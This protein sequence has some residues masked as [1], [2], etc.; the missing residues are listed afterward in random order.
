M[1]KELY[2]IIDLVIRANE[3]AS[4]V[5]LDS[6]VKDE[7]RA[8]MELCRWFPP[9]DCVAV[10]DYYY[11]EFQYWERGKT[12]S[13]LTLLFEFDYICLIY[14]FVSSVV[15]SRRIT[16]YPLLG[17]AKTSR[18]CILIVSTQSIFCLCR[19]CFCWSNQVVTKVGS[20]TFHSILL[21]L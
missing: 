6:V 3:N 4:T 8:I 9:Q 16:L 13:C 15:D 14:A 12:H 17:R 10:F 18:V 5:Q 2:H 21:H 11:V 1:P 20:V 19:E 7:A